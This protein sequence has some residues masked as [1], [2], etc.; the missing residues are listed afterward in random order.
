M[1][2]LF[3]M[4]RITDGSRGGTV[5]Q[6]PVQP[7]VVRS[8]GWI[9]KNSSQF[10]LKNRALRL[11]PV[12]R[13]DI[14]SLLQPCV[15]IQSNRKSGLLDGVD[16]SMSNKLIVQ[17]QGVIERDKVRFVQPD[18][19]GIEHQSVF[20]KSPGTA[21]DASQ[22]I[23][24]QRCRKGGQG[25]DVKSSF[26]GLHD[27]ATGTNSREEFCRRFDEVGVCI[28][29]NYAAAAVTQSML[30]RTNLPAVLEL[31]RSSPLLQSRR[32]NCLEFDR[33]VR[34]FAGIVGI[35]ND[36]PPVVFS[37]GHLAHRKY[38]V[39]GFVKVG[40][41]AVNK[42][43]QMVHERAAQLADTSAPAR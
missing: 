39:D 25:G 23:C 24:R 10:L 31:A 15:M 27:T 7:L 28:T 2:P 33:K 8:N 41:L 35:D 43:K 37:P 6:N 17:V 13:Y 29:Q 9:V 14:A 30:E 16:S 4:Q 19:S 22:V 40:G 20:R 36:A 38:R 32:V 5:R 3:R 12:M 18:D 21:A 42:I 34:H 11:E 1:E 26:A